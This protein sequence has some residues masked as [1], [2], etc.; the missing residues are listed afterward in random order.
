MST[1][2]RVRIGRDEYLG[3]AEEVLAF[4]ARAEG[5]PG[6]D[7]DGYMAGVARRLREQ[8]GVEG[9]PVDDAEAFLDA[10]G[11]RGVAPVERLGEPAT[12]RVLPEEI[13]GEGPVVF[14]PGV[15]PEDL[16]DGA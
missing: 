1:L 7:E 10:L 11:E 4:M 5:G 16:A 15:H 14:G 13:L 3:S 8:L 12:D 6:T 2:Y 9:I